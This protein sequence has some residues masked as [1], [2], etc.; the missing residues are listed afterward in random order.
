MSPKHIE[1]RKK[2][3]LEEEL[4]NIYRVSLDED[5]LDV[6]ERRLAIVLSRLTPGEVNTVRGIDKDVEQKTPEVH[7]IYGQFVC[8]LGGKIFNTLPLMWRVL[9][10][11]MQA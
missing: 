9:L 8:F 6:L 5:H 1:L 10:A 2:Y 11:S 7:G 3:M 4:P